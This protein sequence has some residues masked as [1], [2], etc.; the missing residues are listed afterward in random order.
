MKIIEMTKEQAVKEI[1][2]SKGNTVLVAICDL[3]KDEPA[4]FCPKLKTDCVSLFEDAKTTV[5]VC[6][7]FMKQLRLFTEQQRDI[8]NIEPHGIQKTILIRE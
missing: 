2:K 1:K 7:D 5:S 3:E 8:K 6:D 4:M